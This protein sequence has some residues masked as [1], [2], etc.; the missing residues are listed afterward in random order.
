M[1]TTHQATVDQFPQDI[2]LAVIQRD[3]D[4][5]QQRDPHA[6]PV[7]LACRRVT[8]F[9]GADVHVGFDRV[10]VTPDHQEGQAPEPIIYDLGHTG[11]RFVSAFDWHRAVEPVVVKLT[12]QAKREVNPDIEAE[13]H[14]YDQAR[15]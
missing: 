12:R 11:E 4:E 6:C 15:G 9:Q 7:A 13:A 8:A 14:A 3:I 1:E 10:R 5:G 2:D